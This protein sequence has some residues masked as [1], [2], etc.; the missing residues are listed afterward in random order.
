MC[1]YR[2]NRVATKNVEIGGVVIP[3][4]VAVD[5]PIVGFHYDPELWN[6]PEKFDPER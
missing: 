3:S 4:G 6:E 2:V 1:H 5:I